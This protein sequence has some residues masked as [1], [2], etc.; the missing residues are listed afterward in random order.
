MDTNEK[1]QFES[2]GMNLKRLRKE[3]NLTQDKV[4]LDT[5]IA[6]TTINKY[7]SGKLIPTKENID[8]LEEYFHLKPGALAH[9][10]AIA[11]PN[12]SALL[13]NKRL[14]DFLLEDYEIVI[15]PDVVQKELSRKKNIRVEGDLTAEQ[16]K[17]R[18]QAS[19]IM[20]SILEYMELKETK[21]RV[22]RM[23][24]SKYDV[25]LYPEESKDDG[26]IIE[27]AKDVEIKR[28]RPVDIIHVDKDIPSLGGPKIHA[29]YLDE[30]MTHRDENKKNLQEVIDFDLVYDHLERYEIAANNM[31]LDAYLPDGMTLLISCI[32]CNEPDKV[33]ERGGREIPDVLMHKKLK[34]LLDHGA[35][36]DIP[37]ANQYC[38]TPIEHCIERHYPDFEAFKI[39]LEYGADYNKC[40]VDQTKKRS[41][42]I[43]GINEGNTP[44]MIA[45][46]QGKE[47]FVNRLIE[48][49]DLSINQ[50][51]CNGYTALMK[52]AVRRYQQITNGFRH[53][54]YDRIYKSL[55]ERP[56][57]MGSADL[58]IRDRNNHTALDWWKRGDD[59]A[60]KED[61]IWGD[62]R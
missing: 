30:Y 45:C 43:S 47:K 19:Q 40:S 25:S 27:L 38:H 56:V 23:D 15:I 5:Q 26:R 36:P 4:A 35:D 41:K 20:S 37:D 28:S 49:K 50:Q 62:E 10:T 6:R 42:R 32:R 33:K 51:D 12:S 60:Y 61:E 14:I 57:E 3:R 55:V 1:K 31:D 16:K 7:E 18:K 48:E 21:D 44:L 9:K 53:D 13:R 2:I 17:N 54:N 39:L 22:I 24:T 11:I 29:V 8:R 58:K 46:W 59:P 52:C 34:F